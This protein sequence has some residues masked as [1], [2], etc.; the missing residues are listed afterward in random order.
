MTV[1]KETAKE[2]RERLERERELAES[3]YN[4]PRRDWVTGRIRPVLPE[5]E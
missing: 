4:D 5:D 1:R 2:R 3:M